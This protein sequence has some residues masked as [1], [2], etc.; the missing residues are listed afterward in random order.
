MEIDWR[1]VADD[2]QNYADAAEDAAR[3]D[4]HEPRKWKWAT[5]A[6]VTHAIARALKAGFNEGG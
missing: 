5:V 1:K 2:L 3:N 4:T 6:A